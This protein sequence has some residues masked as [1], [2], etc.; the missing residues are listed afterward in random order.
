MVFENPWFCSMVCLNGTFYLSHPWCFTT[1]DFYPWYF[2]KEKFNNVR[3]IIYSF[4]IKHSRIFRIVHSSYS[5]E[6][7]GYW[8]WVLFLVWFERWG[9]NNP[10]WASPLH[11]AYL[12]YVS[13]CYFM[14]TLITICRFS[15]LL[16]QHTSLLGLIPQDLDQWYQRRY[17]L[18]GNAGLIIVRV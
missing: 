6:L 14:H 1:Y 4:S 17:A 11:V 10:S 12:I 7:L 5:I 9:S 8:F 16:S 18:H 13:L 2:P 3:N 15:L